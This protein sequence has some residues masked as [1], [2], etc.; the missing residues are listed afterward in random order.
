MQGIPA[1][2]API[3][4][5]ELEEADEVF[6]ATTAGGVMPVARVGTRILGND[7]P[8]PLSLALKAAYWKK[9]EEGW[10]RT[11]VRGLSEMAE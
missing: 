8:G 9:H 3:T 5:A 6:C 7:R 11:S 1:A 2:V 4:C 10:H